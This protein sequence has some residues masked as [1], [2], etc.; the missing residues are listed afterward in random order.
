MDSFPNRTQM[1]S[2]PHRPQMDSFPHRTQMDSFPHRTQMDSL[3]EK[4]NKKGGE[5][6]SFSTLFIVFTFSRFI[7][8]V[9]I[10]K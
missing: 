4:Q 7:N 8:S 9:F 10:E 5:K 2:F 1:D 6:S 3:F